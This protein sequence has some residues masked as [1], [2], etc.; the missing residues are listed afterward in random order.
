MPHLEVLRE[1]VEAGDR[2]TA[3]Q[4]TREAL[5][6]GVNPRDVLAPMTSAMNVIGR[7]FSAAEIFVPEM[8]LAA[9]AMKEALEVLEPELTASGIRPEHTVVIGTI[10]G[11]LHDI[12]KNLVCMMLKGAGFAVADLGVGVSAQQFLDA[13][14]EHGASLVGVSALLTTTMTGMKDVVETIRTNLP[15]V[16]VIV[17]G[18]PV[19]P[20]YAASIG[21]DAYAQD[22]GGAVAAARQALGVPEPATSSA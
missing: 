14:K 1:A 21:A 19:T 13:A 7:R 22:A 15:E 3:V 17:G 9:R 16:K 5:A 2:R 4:V 11:D 10:K 12:G 8:L 6:A 20:E 18:A